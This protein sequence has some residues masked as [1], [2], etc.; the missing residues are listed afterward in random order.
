MSILL[1]LS[2]GFLYLQANYSDYVPVVEC[3]DYEVVDCLGNC[4]S[5]SWVGDW[6]CDDA[7]R[8]EEYDWDGG[9]CPS[10]DTNSGNSNNTSG[11]CCYEVYMTDSYGDSWNG[12]YLTLYVNSSSYDELS[13][14]NYQ[15]E[16]IYQFCLD[17][18]DSFEF[19]YTSGSYDSE[20]SFSISE[21]G[22]E[23]Y[24]TSNPS[25]GFHYGGYCD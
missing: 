5:Q 7:F 25:S 22:S 21:G 20:N 18:Y 24:S 19:Y 23:L 9:D 13:C 4:T 1:F 14:P 3:D 11:D 17:Y 16:E 12:A 2:C 6:E 15:T 8:C 10:G